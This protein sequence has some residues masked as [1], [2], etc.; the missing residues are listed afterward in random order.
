MLELLGVLALL[1]HLRQAVS[2]FSQVWMV[3]KASGSPAASGT[4]KDSSKVWL[5]LGE[6]L[7]GV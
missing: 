5:P 7:G 1:G 2:P 3:G 4:W 6:R